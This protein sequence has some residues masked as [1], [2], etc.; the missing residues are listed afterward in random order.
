MK[1]II[2][3]I[4]ILSSSIIHAHGFYNNNGFF[5]N[6]H[7]NNMFYDID[8]QFKNLERRIKYLK[9]SK[10]SFRSKSKKFFDANSNEYV[11]QITTNNMAKENL[12]ITI[13]ENTLKIIGENKVEQQ[14]NNNSTILSSRFSQSFSLP[15]DADYDNIKANFKDNM[16]TIRIP[17]IVETK[18]TEK[19]I[20]IG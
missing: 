9:K 7:Y 3:A 10:S 5:G 1:I 18:T 4:T 12:S 17:K 11:I 13:N 20:E 14:N 19:T 2:F 8:S 16:L 15:S 6:Q